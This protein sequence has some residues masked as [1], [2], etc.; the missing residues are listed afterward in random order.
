MQPVSDGGGSERALIQMARRLAAGGWELHVALPG[1]ARLASEYAEAGVALH[2]VPMARLTTSGPAW[3]WAGYAARW[4]STVAALAALARRVGAD[5]MHSNSLHSWY[6]WAAARLAGLPH[7]WHARE[8][9]FQSPA[10]LAVERFLARRFAE[11]VVA[12]SAA[13]AAQLD[14]SNV[15]VLTDE[16]DPDVF[17]PQRAGRFRAAAGIGDDVPLA[18]S[19]ARLD[20]WKGFEVLLDAFPLVRRARPD[21]ELVVAGSPVP[22]RLDYAEG[23][24]RRAAAVEGVRW[25]GP[26]SDVADLMADLDVFVQVSTEPEPF[27]LVVVE[28]LASG[29]PVVAG[30][31]GGPLE[32][33]GADAA[34]RPTP[35]GRLVE[36][37]DPA[38]LADA[39]LALLPPGP[40]AATLR[41][42]RRPLR[43]PRSDGFTSVFDEVLDG[44]AG[45]RRRRVPRRT[46]PT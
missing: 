46:P 25:L 5:V 18:G 8:I 11:R 4:P 23:L 41:R 17:R 30:A 29:V 32:I 15:V 2:V 19:V 1:P 34:R 40:S 20:T 31:A 21:A 26:R 36:P 7:V 39:V 44:R 27:G 10:A 24:A 12:V 22:S 16:A 28:A 3:R 45:G 37:G 38:A 13:V 33:L 35:L 14:S 42:A 43:E 6:G 9:V